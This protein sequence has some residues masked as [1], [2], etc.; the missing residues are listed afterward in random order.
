MERRG[1]LKSLGHLETVSEFLLP[2]LSMFSGLI[3]YSQSKLQSSGL[4]IS[5]RYGRVARTAQTVAL[6]E[7]LL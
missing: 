1:G 6:T 2:L 4:N 7:L 3:Q 5:S